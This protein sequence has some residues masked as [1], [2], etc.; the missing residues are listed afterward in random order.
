MVIKKRHRPDFQHLS[1]LL[2]WP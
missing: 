1:R 2:G